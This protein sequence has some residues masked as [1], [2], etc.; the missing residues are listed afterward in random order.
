MVVM[1]GK[2]PEYPLG[3]HRRLDMSEGGMNASAGGGVTGRADVGVM[4]RRDVPATDFIA[5]AQQAEALGFD[6]V[7][8][9]EDLGYWGGI[10]QA[11]AIASATNRIRV[12]VGILPVA[13]RNVA[14]AAME[15]STL[16]ELF[17]GRFTVGIGHGLPEWIQQVNAWPKS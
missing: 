11:A 2:A 17:P 1:P 14:Y 12:G 16:A 6:E 10:A 5:F 13:A 15:L 8:V 9:V 7:W 3:S 4:L